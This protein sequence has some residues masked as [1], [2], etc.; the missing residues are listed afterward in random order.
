MKPKIL[1]TGAENFGRGGRSVIAWNLTDSLSRDFQID[2][3]S[4]HQVEDENYFQKIASRGAEIKVIHSNKKL[5]FFEIL[6]KLR[7]MYKILSSGKYDIVHINADDAWEA[8]KIIL[9][10]RFVGIKNFVIHGHSTLSPKGEYLW[11]K[12]LNYLAKRYFS[13]LR[14][15]QKVACSLE[16][17]NY[18]FGT[19]ADVTIIENGIKLSDYRFQNSIRKEVRQDL[20][21]SDATVVVGT[22]GRF[23]EA[24]NPFFTLDIIEKLVQKDR[25]FHFL[26]VGEG[27]LKNEVEKKAI[28]KNVADSITFLGNRSDVNRLLQSF[29]VFILPSIN[30]GFGIVNI[31]AQAT[32]CPCLVS[33]NIPDIA[34]VNNNFYFLPL[35]LGA[36]IWSD[37]IENISNQRQS[38]EHVNEFSSSGFDISQGA[39]KLKS[40]YQKLL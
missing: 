3:L 9:I 14:K 27:P 16:A 33:D 23:V 19:E 12:I 38:L 10:A 35:S 31:E 34:K 15:L 30:E 5:I 17:A 24:K 22:I 18:L 21:I 13:K 2:F 29:D 20:N 26:W 11:R 1:M 28:E 8:S 37:K 6:A 7:Q 36:D 25:E 32:G 39:L 40:I 4:R